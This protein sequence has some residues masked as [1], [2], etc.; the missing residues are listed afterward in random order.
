MSQ[1][2]S[3]I[4]VFNQTDILYLVEKKKNLIRIGNTI[5]EDPMK[6][7]VRDSILISNLAIVKS[8]ESN[9]S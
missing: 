2:I 7:L 1:T 9:G 8:N 6:S 5:Q 3:K 4:G